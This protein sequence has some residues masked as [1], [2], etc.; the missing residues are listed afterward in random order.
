MPTMVVLAF[1]EADVAV[2]VLLSPPH[3]AKIINS[4]ANKRLY[5]AMRLD[6]YMFFSIQGASSRLV[7]RER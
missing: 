2:A 1:V 4:A 6:T 7:R 5:Q 3:A